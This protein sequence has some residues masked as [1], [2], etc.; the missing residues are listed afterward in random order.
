MCKSLACFIRFTTYCK[1]NE[2]NSSAFPFEGAFVKGID[3]VSWMAN[4]SSKL[5]SGQGNG[6][7]C[8]TFFSTAAF[9]ERTKVPQKNIPNATAE[10]VKIRMLEGVEIALGLSKGSLKRPLYSR[11]QLWG[12]A[13]PTNSPG[14][15][16][17]FD[18]HGRAGMCGDWLLGSSLESAAISGMAIVISQIIF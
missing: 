4:N 11:L 7:H 10:K 12:A 9:G 3:A 18:A 14:V 17:I 5:S 13:L 15:P 8:W 2:G 1:T 6:P 16:C